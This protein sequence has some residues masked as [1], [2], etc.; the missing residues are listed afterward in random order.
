MEAVARSTLSESM[1]RRNPDIFKALFEE[2]LDR[3]MAYAPKH[4]FK[5]TIHCMPSI[6]QRLTFVWLAMTGLIT[7]NIKERL[8]YTQ[9]LIYQAICRVFWWWATVK[10]PIFKPQK[11]TFRFSRTASTP[12]IK[13]IMT[14]IGLAVF[15]LKSVQ[16]VPFVQNLNSTLFIRATHL[17]GKFPLGKKSQIV[18]F[19]TRDFLDLFRKF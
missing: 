18:Q 2:L 6:A 14:L 13:A 17:K 8:D 11:T 4:K 19:L 1:N 16:S 9:N 10:C 5:S 3:V 15:G 12:L 7:E